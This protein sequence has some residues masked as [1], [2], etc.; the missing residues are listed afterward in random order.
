MEAKGAKR[1]EIAGSDD[2][3][4]LTALFSCTLNG[5]FFLS[6]LA[7]LQRNNISSVEVPA[8]FIDHLQPSDLSVNKPVKDHLKASFQEWYAIGIIWQRVLAG[9]DDKKVI[10]LCLSLLKPLT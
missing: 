10:D 7:A 4:Q 2:K 9:N 5:N 6:F 1:V 3:R 8:N